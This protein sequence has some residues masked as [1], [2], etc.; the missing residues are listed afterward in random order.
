MKEEIKAMDI[1]SMEVDKFLHK[2]LSNS[3]QYRKPFKTKLAA[4]Y[5]L[6]SASCTKPGKLCATG[7]QLANDGMGLLESGGWMLS[8]KVIRRDLMPK[9]SGLEDSEIP[10]GS[11]SMF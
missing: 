1:N 8:W 11:D 2:R 5:L 7:A 10:F 9:G 3:P 6:T 4:L